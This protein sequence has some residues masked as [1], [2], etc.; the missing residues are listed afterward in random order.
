MTPEQASEVLAALAQRIAKFGPS[1][2]EA[3]QLF[4]CAHLDDLVSRKGKP[5]PQV[6][7]QAGL[8][9]AP[10]SDL[11]GLPAYAARI[12]MAH[13]LVRAPGLWTA[14]AAE[15]AS[16]AG[17]FP[18]RV[19]GALTSIKEAAFDAPQAADRWKRLG[20]GAPDP[21][22]MKLCDALSERF[23]QAMVCEICLGQGKYSCSSCNGQGGVL[24]LA[25]KATGKVVDP[26]EGGKVLCSMCKGRGATACLI[27]NGQKSI[28]C[29]SCDGK[30]TRP[31]VAGGSYRWLV[32]LGLCDACEGEGSLF[33]SAAWPCPVCDGN[34]RLFDRFLKEY[35]RL[36]VW[37]RTREG[38]SL[39]NALRWL[40]RHQS[41]DGSWET[42]GWSDHCK[43]PGCTAPSA[44]PAD[45]DIG[46][47]SLALVSFVSA[48]LGPD[49]DLE[50]GRVPAGSVIRKA[51]G[52]LL[53]QQ[54]PD[55]LISRV[56]PGKAPTSIKPVYEN[57]MATY[58]LFTAASS[59]TPGEAFSERDKQALKEAAFRALKAAL[60]LQNK[61]AGWGYTPQAPSDSW[62][63]SWGAAALLAA[64]EAGV[65]VPRMSLAWITMW[66][67]TCTDKK[68]FH[69]GYQPAQ[70]GKVNLSGNETFLHHDTLS[71][72]G[73][74]MRMQIEGKPTGTVAAA[75]KLV[76]MD[77]PNPDPLRRDFCYWY[78]GTTF[79]VQREQ[80]KGSGWSAWSQAAVRESILLQQ[81]LDT[82]TLGAWLPDDR[83]SPMGGK[84]Y[85]TAI[86]A[87][88]LEQVQGLIPLKASKSK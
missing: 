59:I 46:L 11:F 63:T 2:P 55:G 27:C 83:W 37:L 79:L 44:K 33:K 29:A 73:G 18:A 12:E 47:T 26:A 31:G 77:L 23:R 85:A 42:F 14:R 10:A 86:N 58:A 16:T 68:D 82:C 70:M 17:D 38:R 28:K 35:G 48:G 67:D 20:L 25:C 60:A 4:A 71:A 3:L 64:R 9:R 61:G 43:E 66:F 45:F 51:I 88:L 1:F 19:L 22:W 81:P 78:L 41:P 7:Q 74:L 15:A 40:A 72:F 30:K 69:L 5:D 80:R 57:L 75:D 50:L 32:D 87:L 13:F 54:Q 84:V 49:S 62:V 56:G 65:D 24:C 8:S 34:G 6:L 39:W 76:A 21:A 36:P 53:A 52:W